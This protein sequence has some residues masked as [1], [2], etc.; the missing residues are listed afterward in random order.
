MSNKTYIVPQ[1]TT[2]S[3]TVV[4]FSVT[5]RSLTL[6]TSASFTVD[7]F[8]INDNLILRQVLTLDP[9]LYETWLGDD[10]FIITWVEGQLGF[11]PIDDVASPE[12]GG[13]LPA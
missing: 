5:C 11:T 6:F 4:S 8:D 7:T 1:T 13:T 3:V 9:T 10:S 12:E 2:T